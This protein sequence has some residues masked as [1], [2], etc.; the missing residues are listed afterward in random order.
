MRRRKG[1]EDGNAIVEFALWT[2]IVLVAL[3]TCLQLM[4]HLYAERSAGAAA[5]SAARAL[6]AGEDPEA[7]A[8]AALPAGAPEATVTVTDG[9]V[10]VSMPTRRYL[11]LLPQKFARV[12]ASAPTREDRP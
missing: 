2:P 5:L 12:T 1:R 8:R 3:C 11:V 4:A 6:G 7:A 10:Q 9:S